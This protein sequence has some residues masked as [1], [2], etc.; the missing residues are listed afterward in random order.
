M[1]SLRIDDFKVWG[2]TLVGLSIG[3][4]A[5]VL[6]LW[7]N[8][9]FSSW[10]VAASV[11]I[12]TALATGIMFVYTQNMGLGEVARILTRI[13][14]K[15]SVDAFLDRGFPG[16]LE[17]ELRLLQ[18]AW[19]QELMTL[20]QQLASAKK[21]TEIIHVRSS[22]ALMQL[23]QFLNRLNRTD[24]TNET[25]AARLSKII[26]INRSLIE[27]D[28]EMGSSVHEIAGDVKKA[29]QTANEGIKNVGGEIRA[30]SD[31]RSTVG[32]SATIITELNDMARHI[33]EFVNRIG[34]IAR[35]THLLSLN[36]GIEAAR[37]GDAGRG[38]AVVAA[39]IRTLS[40]TAKQA[41]VEISGLIH[42]I[43]RRTSEVVDVLKNTDKL[44]E[45][46]KV[47]YSAGDTFMHIVR[48]VKDIDSRVHRF[49]QL[50]SETFNDSQ[51]VAKLLEELRTGM[52]EGKVTYQELERELNSMVRAWRELV[53]HG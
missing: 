52:E 38:F 45:S 40:E 37:A 12:V 34:G 9:T 11:A 36:A 5:E 4:L 27:S 43:H 18:N 33:Q 44:E 26:T 16:V 15:H 14:E 2:P 47:V 13:S 19:S 49:D 24:Q 28:Q 41:T 22:E 3:V 17:S 46:I 25:L 10:Y 48:E 51:L 50:I 20:Q 29:T 6:L 30:M 1:R 39:E 23:E 35:Q 21:E 7:W 42:E 31:L 8:P 32:S 53:P